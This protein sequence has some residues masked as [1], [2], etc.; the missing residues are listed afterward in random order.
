MMRAAAEKRK[1]EMDQYL[2]SEQKKKDEIKLKKA[3]LKKV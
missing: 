3:S 2:E 1:E